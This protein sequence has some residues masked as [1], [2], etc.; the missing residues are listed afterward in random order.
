MRKMKSGASTRSAL[1]D[2]IGAGAAA[3]AVLVPIISDNLISYN[4][5]NGI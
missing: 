1:P 2:F 5:K 4:A 3:L